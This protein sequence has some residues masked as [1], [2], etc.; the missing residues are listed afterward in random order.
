MVK[1]SF[2]TLA[3]EEKTSL[4]PISWRN[5][6]WKNYVLH[7]CRAYENELEKL[8]AFCGI[9]TEILLQNPLLLKACLEACSFIWD[10]P[11]DDYIDFIPA[12]HKVLVEK[13]AWGKIEAAKSAISAAGDYPFKAGEEIVRLYL[14][15][16]IGDLPCIEAIGLVGFFLRR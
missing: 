6:T 1:V 7:S 14:E 8:A 9:E 12:K 11:L 2:Q 3:G 4:I 10:T 16:E 13:E 5:V 15:I